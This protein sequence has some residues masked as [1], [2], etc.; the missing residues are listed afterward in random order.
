MLS[1][2]VALGAGINELRKP[3]PLLTPLDLPEIDPLEQLPDLSEIRH[4]PWLKAA[5][6]E[7]LTPLVVAE[8]QRIQWQR[9]QLQLARLHLESGMVLLPQDS[10]L[11][12]E[13]LAEYGLVLPETDADWERVLRRIDQVPADLV[14][15]QAANESGWGRSRFAQEGN[16]L[17]GQWCFS[18][19]C[20]LVPERRIDG[21]NHEVR[22]FDTVQDSVRAYMRN[23]N[24]HRA[25]AGLR[26]LRAEL[27]EEAEELT[28]YLLAAG[29]LSY[30]ERGEAYV[31]E[32]RAMLRDNQTQIEEALSQAWEQLFES[33][34]D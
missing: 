8:N 1:L 22:R 12:D 15:M 21:F 26:R 17:F 25:Y 7:L 32:V 19:G 23:I 18:A 34:N 20:G 10:L 24:T 28:G 5:F 3:A 9:E 30:S 29:L 27:Q 2:L 16:N 31:Q 13:I 6:F 14:L 11:L 33:P 4:V